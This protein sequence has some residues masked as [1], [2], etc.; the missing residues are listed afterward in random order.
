[1]LDVGAKATNPRTGS[2]W[3]LMELSEDAFVLRYSIPAGVSKPEVAEHY[4]VGWQEEFCV[5]EGQGAYRLDGTT[6]RI[7]A[8]D[9]V[10]FPEKVRHVHPFST[11]SDPMIIDQVG[12][13]TN[14]AP[15]AIR[16]TLG[17]FFTMF[18]WE[19]AGRT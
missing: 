18:E 8:G 13:L 1:M 5:H 3:E 15:N 11:G 7:D 10:T 16:N 19:A 4:H 9:R 14:P 17:F 12:K 6:H 2:R